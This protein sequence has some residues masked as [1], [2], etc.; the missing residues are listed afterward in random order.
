M[1]T[2][3][4]YVAGD[5]SVQPGLTIRY[6]RVRADRT[7]NCEAAM[8]CRVCPPYNLRRRPVLFVDVHLRGGRHDGAHVQAEVHD[9]RLIVANDGSRYR[10]T[11]RRDSSHGCGLTVF[12]AYGRRRQMLASIAPRLTVL[13][14]RGREAREAG[15]GAKCRSG[16]S[17]YS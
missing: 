13:P 16:P 5:P 9:R 2:V 12:R 6:V 8:G 3:P 4:R 11:F 15:L 17:E 10:R 7:E 14:R 1:G